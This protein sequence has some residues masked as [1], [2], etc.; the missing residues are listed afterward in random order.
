MGRR[1][2]RESRTGGHCENCHRLVVLSSTPLL[3]FGHFW[4]LCCCVHCCGA[5]CCCDISE[6]S[7]V[8]CIVCVCVWEREWERECQFFLVRFKRASVLNQSAKQCGNR[9]SDSS[10][11]KISSNTSNIPFFVFHQLLK[12][13]KWILFIENWAQWHLFIFNN[14]CKFW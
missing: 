8:S 7:V 6:A 5:I 11:L 13:S 14:V 10:M 4:G 9:F 1:G 12:D 2:E 3:K